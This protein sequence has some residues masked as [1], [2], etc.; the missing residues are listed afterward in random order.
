MGIGRATLFY[1]VSF[2]IGFIF[3]YTT[4]YRKVKQ[5]KLLNLIPLRVLTIY[6]VSLIT[7]VVVLTL[8]GKYHSLIELYKQ[9]AVI[10]LPAMIGASAADLIKGD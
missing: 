3:I 8:F 6:A 5:V 7:V 4:G 1:L 9:V 10:S 2:T